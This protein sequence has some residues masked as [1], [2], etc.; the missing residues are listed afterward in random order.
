[1]RKACVVNCDN[2]RTVSKSDLVERIATFSKGRVAKIK[3][4]VGYA[5]AWD[6]L[7]GARETLQ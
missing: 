2:L 5:L 1:M 6:E 4:A 3:A 7:F